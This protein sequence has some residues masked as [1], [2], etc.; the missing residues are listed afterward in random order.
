LQVYFA[1]NGHMAP[2]TIAAKNYVL[3]DAG[4]RACDGGTRA[5]H[6]LAFEGPA[7]RSDATL[8]ILDLTLARDGDIVGAILDTG[9]EVAEC[10]SLLCGDAPYAFR[11]GSLRYV[12]GSSDDGFTGNVLDRCDPALVEPAASAR[13]DAPPTPARFHVDESVRGVYRAG[14]CSQSGALCFERGHCPK[15]EK[16]RFS[17]SPFYAMERDKKANSLAQ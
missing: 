12:T 14:L 2:T 7:R 10:D 3:D 17:A 4:Q 8:Q 9:A 6:L 11:S 13:G 16:C 5:H 1:K 15:R